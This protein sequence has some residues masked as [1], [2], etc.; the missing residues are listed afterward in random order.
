MT[1]PNPTGRRTRWRHLLLGIGS[2]VGVVAAIGFWVWPRVPPSLSPLPLAEPGFPDWPH[3]RG[4]NYDAISTE[5][6][7]A[8]VWP[9]QGP[10]VLWQRDLGQGYSGFV[11]MRGRAF[12]QTQTLAGQFVVC[13]DAETGVEQWRHRYGWPWQPA[14][15]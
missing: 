3:L 4:P 7:L 6:G 13:L 10:P 5:T 9:E 2:L 8:D 12:T 15:R 1:T 14:G 11:V